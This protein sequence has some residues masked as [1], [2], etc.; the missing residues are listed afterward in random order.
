MTKTLKKQPVK[1][2]YTTK[3]TKQEHTPDHLV[4]KPVQKAASAEEPSL[5]PVLEN[6]EEIKQEMFPI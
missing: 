6:H 3:Q 2:K 4:Y 5:S 1:G